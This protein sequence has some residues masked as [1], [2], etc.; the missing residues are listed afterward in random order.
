MM[1]IK[2]LLK[3]LAVPVMI[4]C[5]LI[6]FLIDMAAKVS[7][8]ILGPFTLFVLGCV[9]YTIVKQ[10]WNQTILLALI[11]A[12][13]IAV[14]FGAGV[15]STEIGGIGDRLGDFIRSR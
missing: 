13:C 7:C 5:K 9:I 8:L 14:L 15:L 4:L 11:E 2:F 12:V 3:I 10:A 6:R 1:I